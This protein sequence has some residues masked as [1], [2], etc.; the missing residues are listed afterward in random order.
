MKFFSLL[1]MGCLFLAFGCNKEDICGENLI[2]IEQ[3]I[4][5]NNLNVQ[6]GAEGLLY[7]IEDPGGIDRPSSTAS[8]TVNYR[9]VTTDD[10]VFDETNGSAVP[11]RLSNLIRGWQLGI[12]LVGQGGRV[13]LFIPSELGYGSRAVGS[14]CPNSDLIFD[15]ELVSFSE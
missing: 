12:P 9:G 10:V 15:I 4:M 7:I 1:F 2:T 6:E 5:D 11:F 14:I 8:V 13:K 3:Y